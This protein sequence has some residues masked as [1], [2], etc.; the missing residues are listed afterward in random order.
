MNA[1]AVM[2]KFIKLGDFLILPN[3]HNITLYLIIAERFLHLYFP[4]RCLKI[5]KACSTERFGIEPKCASYGP[6]NGHPASPDAPARLRLVNV[7]FREVSCFIFTNKLRTVLARKRYHFRFYEG[8]FIYV[9]IILWE[10]NFWSY[11]VKASLMACF[12]IIKVSLIH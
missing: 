12:S 11:R 10:L 6:G 3:L 7:K 9:F 5:L 1:K 2:W 4:E 8:A